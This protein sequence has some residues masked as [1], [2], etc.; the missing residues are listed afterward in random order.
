MTVYAVHAVGTDFVK[1]GYTK[2]NNPEKRVKDM[3]TDCPYRLAILGHV[4][5]CNVSFEGFIH[6]RLAE[7]N[8]RGEWFTLKEAERAIVLSWL[9]AEHVSAQYLAYKKQYFMLMAMSPGGGGHE[10]L[11]DHVVHGDLS[12]ER[13]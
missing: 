10:S 5:Q 3:G 2:N 4:D 6:R 11:G 9:L 12:M 8:V 7:K 13:P 1:I